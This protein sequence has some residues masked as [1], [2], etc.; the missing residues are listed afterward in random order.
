M[1][2][3]DGVQYKVYETSIHEHSNITVF[4]YLSATVQTIF[5]YWKKIPD[6]INHDYLTNNISDF[7]CW[8][9][10]LL[11]ICDE[12]IP[13]SL[14]YEIENDKFAIRKFI[15]QTPVDWDDAHYEKP[16]INLLN[17]KLLLAHV[18]PNKNIT[19]THPT[20]PQLSLWGQ[21]II[22]EEVPSEPRV[23]A[24]TAKR[25]LWIEQAVEKA[26]NEDDNEN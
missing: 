15:I 3:I 11:F 22:D 20:L 8:N 10:Y 23:H 1:P 19:P 7:E 25:Q 12:A 21:G 4:C 14:K 9:S 13:K 24:S 18:E 2:K 5:E 26:M 6:Y 16:L 17:N